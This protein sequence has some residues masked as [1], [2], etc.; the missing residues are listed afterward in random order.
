MS[1][2]T[3]LDLLL[4]VLTGKLIYVL[5]SKSDMIIFNVMVISKDGTITKKKKKTECS[6]KLFITSD[7]FLEMSL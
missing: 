3:Y 5:V 4:K 7:V 2:H 6:I 1:P